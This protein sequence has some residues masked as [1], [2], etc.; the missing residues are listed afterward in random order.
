MTDGTLTL[1]EDILAD[2][3]NA[4]GGPQVKQSPGRGYGLF[5][6]RDYKTEES[7]D[8]IVVAVY[9]GTRYLRDPRGIL[10]ASHD[11]YLLKFT[12]D[13]ARDYH[14]DGTSGFGLMEKGRWINHKGQDDGEGP[15]AAWRLRKGTEHL[16]L[17]HIVI[18][19]YLID[20]VREG[21]EFFID[22]GPEYEELYP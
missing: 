22:Y 17:E 1:S 9:N 3:V 19:I 7:E 18:E 4:T 8:Y 15:N 11:K 16:S 5:A 2:L 20:D 12:M 21:E 14:V 10:P 6:D 13:D